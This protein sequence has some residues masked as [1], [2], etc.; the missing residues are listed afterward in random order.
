MIGGGRARVVVEE[1][2]DG[3]NLG[4]SL[5]AADGAALLAQNAVE[6]R[7]GYG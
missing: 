5:N 4:I 2:V 1:K 3:A 7:N 6:R